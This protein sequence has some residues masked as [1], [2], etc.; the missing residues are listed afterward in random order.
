MHKAHAKAEQGTSR[1]AVEV[2]L[3]SMCMHAGR[4][5]KGATGMLVRK[6]TCTPKTSPLKF[7]CLLA[8][9]HQSE[10]GL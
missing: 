6:G 2:Q 10:R 9:Q 7:L 4:Q 3:V 1:M 8:V 5:V